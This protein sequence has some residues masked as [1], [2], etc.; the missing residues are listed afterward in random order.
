MFVAEIVLSVCLVY[1]LIGLAVG[2]PFVFRGVH[3]IDVATQGGSATFRLT[4]LP[5]SIVLW[6]WVMRRWQQSTKGVGHS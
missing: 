2:V 6:P 3:R 4:I 5:G 1:V